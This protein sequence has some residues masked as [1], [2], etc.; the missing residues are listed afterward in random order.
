VEA[1]RGGLHVRPHSV[2]Q[3]ARTLI[4]GERL[5]LTVQLCSPSLSEVE[6]SEVEGSRA[7]YS[8]R[9]RTM[10]MRIPRMYMGEQI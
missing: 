10:V 1:R 9:G 6:G 4:Y 5:V 2:W 7:I 3:N 8:E